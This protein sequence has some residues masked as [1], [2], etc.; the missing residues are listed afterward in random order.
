MSNTNYIH[1]ANLE[2]ALCYAIR[3]LKEV[4]AK[5]S[6]TFKSTFRA[7]LEENLAE[8]KKGNP[9]VIKY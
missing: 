9:L 5:V 2:N 4:D 3:M 1:E 7:G 6:P 8:M